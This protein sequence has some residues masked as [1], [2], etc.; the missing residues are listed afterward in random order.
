MPYLWGLRFDGG[1]YAD[2]GYGCGVTAYGFDLIIVA[3]TMFRPCFR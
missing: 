2:L 1:C 3:Y